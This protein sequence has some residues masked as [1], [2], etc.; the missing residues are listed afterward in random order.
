[1]IQATVVLS[2]A[3]NVSI[4]VVQSVR[5]I[6]LGTWHLFAVVPEVATGKNQRTTIWY[7][8]LIIQQRSRHTIVHHWFCSYNTSLLLDDLNDLSDIKMSWIT[9]TVF[10]TSSYIYNFNY[11]DQ[12][13]WTT[14]N[15]C[16]TRKRLV[17]RVHPHLCP[18]VCTHDSC[19]NNIQIISFAF[20]I[21]EPIQIQSSSGSSS[22]RFSFQKPFLS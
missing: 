19:I 6:F 18:T 8:V 16:K 12:K 7:P 9:L 5:K 21:Q 17:Y 11:W 2:P 4:F 10:I 3:L 20:H 13:P 14:L 22:I 1:M 15:V